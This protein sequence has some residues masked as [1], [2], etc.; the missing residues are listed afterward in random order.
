MHLPWT[1]SLLVA[2]RLALGNQGS[3]NR[4]ETFSQGEVLVRDVCIIGGGSAGTY[5]A[6][7]LQQSNKSVIVVEKSDHL[8]GHTETF[9]D[10]TTG[11]AVDYGVQ[12]FE[13]TTISTAY[14][15]HLGIGWEGGSPA[16]RQKID[17][18][19]GKLVGEPTESHPNATATR[20]YVDLLR[21]NYPY[22]DTGFS[23][24][25]P[26]PEDL[27]IPFQDF[28]QRHNLSSAV[29]SIAAFNI[30]MG[31]WLAFPAIY[32]MKYAGEAAMQR[33]LVHI[34]GK[35]NSALYGAAQKR[36]GG[37]TL[38]STQV[39][40]VSRDRESTQLVVDT[41]SGRQQ[42]RAKKLIMTIPPLVNDL[43]QFM[44]LHPQELD[45][46]RQF[47]HGYLYTGLV[48]VDGFPSDI[49]RYMNWG[50]AAGGRLKL[51][52]LYV[53]SQTV[54]PGMMVVH[55][56]SDVPLRDEEVQEQVV[57]QLLRFRQAGVYISQ[58]EIVI[59]KSHAPYELRV[60]PP[61]IL[62]GFYNNLNSLQGYQGTFWTGAA[63]ET[64]DSQQIW[65]F[66]EQLI[67]DQVMK[68][69]EE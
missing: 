14:F 20:D 60:S 27:V 9:T 52:A 53:V 31:D 69:L 6:I 10:P 11:K 65:K 58:P 5:A 43:Q 12:S 16:T 61:A 36:L 34:K 37:D 25:N 3:L 22:L 30:D 33:S 39:V 19:A 17:L 23:L 44:D 40:Q 48:R 8:G 41:P 2:A 56:G 51:P 68:S 62:D 55:F 50:T 1:L 47:E 42:I 21:N 67:Q 26:V 24:P 64:H 54:V 66:T 32:S 18:D 63:F 29:D 57:E 35:N 38:L 7:R 28:I 4:D 13:E 59:M 49:T 46:F 15:Q 45:L